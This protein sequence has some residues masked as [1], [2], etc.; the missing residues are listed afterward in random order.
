[1]STVCVSGE[2]SAVDCVV[3]SVDDAAS[4]IG[5]RAIKSPITIAT[6]INNKDIIFLLLISNAP[7]DIWVHTFRNI[8]IC[9]NIN[10]S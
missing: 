5:G 3:A 2:A 10:H 4:A 1:V 9:L 8:Y 7:F 6:A